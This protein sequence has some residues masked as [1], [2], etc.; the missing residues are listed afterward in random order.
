MMA[1]GGCSD[2]DTKL[3]AIDD[4]V[5][6][7]PREHLIEERIPWLPQSEEKGLM[8]LMNPEAPVREQISV[9]I[10]STVVT[11][12][13]KTPPVYSQLAS[14]CESAERQAGDKQ[15]TPP[16]ALEKELQN[17]DPTQWTYRLADKPGDERGDIVANC[18][19]MGDGD[20]LCHSLSNYGDLVYTIGLRESDIQHL[21]AIRERIR[22]LLSSWKRPA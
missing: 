12:N 20:G 22:K 15:K 2:P 18:S 9:L 7:V 14:A 17:G 21:P 6:E 8:F 11:C 19:A 4:H 10:E 3:I 1:P 5:F 13:P 16:S